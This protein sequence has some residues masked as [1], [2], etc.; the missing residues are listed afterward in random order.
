MAAADK[1]KRLD[2][3]QPGVAPVWLGSRRTA[4]QKLFS[5]S[6]LDLYHK[7]LAFIH[8]FSFLSIR[9]E[10]AEPPWSISVT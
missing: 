1:Q 3:S 9:E 8:D 2:L 5:I 10:A 6:I 7:I 4:A